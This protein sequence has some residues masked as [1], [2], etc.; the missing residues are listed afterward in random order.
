LDDYVG[1][2]LDIAGGP[3]GRSFKP[4]S[5]AF[6]SSRAKRYY[7]VDRLVKPIERRSD[8]LVGGE[9]GVAFTFAAAAVACGECQPLDMVQ[10]AQVGAGRGDLARRMQKLPKK[11]RIGFSLII[12]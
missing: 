7:S 6:F 10:A 2:Y 8:V 4:Y 12:L 3:P 9:K 5:Y 1:D 11:R